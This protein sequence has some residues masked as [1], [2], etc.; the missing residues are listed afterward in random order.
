VYQTIGMCVTSY[1]RSLTVSIL[2]TLYIDDR[3]AVS[4]PTLDG[5]G[6]KE[7]LA[8]LTYVVL[9]V[10]SSIHYLDHK[11]ATKLNTKVCIRGLA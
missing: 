7:S 6:H 5:P 8:C 4:N 10:L 11:I 2:N 3:F 9:Q 1:L